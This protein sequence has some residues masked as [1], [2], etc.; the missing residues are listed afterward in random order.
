MPS[1]TPSSLDRNVTAGETP[2]PATITDTE[3]WIQL[4]VFYLLL[5]SVLATIGDVVIAIGIYRSKNLRSRF[6]IFVG[7]LTLIRIITGSQFFVMFAYRALRM[8]GLAEMNLKV[9]LC[10]FIH[11]HI[12]YVGTCEMVLLLVLVL[13]RMLAIMA[14]SRYRNLTSGQ[15]LKLGISVCIG[16][17]LL[18]V[19]PSFFGVDF[20]QV[21][22]CVH[23]YSPTHPTFAQYSQN[24]DLVI[25]L[26]ILLLYI[27]LLVYLRCYKIPPLRGSSNDVSSHAA[28]IALK[29]QMKLMPL[30]RRLVIIHCSFA[31]LTKATLSAAGATPDM[32]SRRLIAY[33]GSLMTVDL[34]ANAVILLASN[35]VLRR[36][37]CVCLMNSVQSVQT[38]T[39][40]VAQNNM[41]M[42]PRKMGIPNPR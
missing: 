35:K 27:V 3:Q 16:T 22:P 26:L 4:V 11:F 8:V 13:D 15:A 10:F 20:Q 34:F 24:I 23:G 1:I 7:F 33:G 39:A 14:H 32:Y 19:V 31:L 9:G 21:A 2:T 25:V 6:F 5:A 36:A 40:V 30:L 37:G 18:K 41:K 12:V 28:T 29:R 42:M 17:F 38:T